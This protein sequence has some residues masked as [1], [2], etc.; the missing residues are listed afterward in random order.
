MSVPKF[1]GR[2]RKLFLNNDIA[3]YSAKS[4]SSLTAKRAS[5]ALTMERQQTELWCWAAVAQ[6]ILRFRSKKP[7]SQ[8][9]VATDHRKQGDF[10]DVNMVADPLNSTCG[11]NGCQGSCNAPHSLTFVM[12]S[13]EV[14]ISSK[15][16]DTFANSNAAFDWIYKQIAENG[17]PV[18]CFMKQTQSGSAAGHFIVI[19]MAQVV[20]VNQRRV[21]IVDPLGAGFSVETV[22]AVATIQNFEDFI[23]GG[24]WSGGVTWKPAKL[25]ELG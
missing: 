8:S 12:Q 14:P 1:L 6:A 4:V 13:L 11:A 2:G 5:I 16:Y 7:G 23:S 25:Y 24:F 22:P 15:N 21:G 9:K 18:P 19:N 10:C 3:N 20:D 17:R